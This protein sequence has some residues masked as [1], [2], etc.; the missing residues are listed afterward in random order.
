MTKKNVVVKKAFAVQN[1]RIF[2]GNKS[3]RFRELKLIK[4]IDNKRG[5]FNKIVK[6]EKL[7]FHQVHFLAQDGFGTAAVLSTDFFCLWKGANQ[8]LDG[9]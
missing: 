7:S 5:S 4:R 1:L 3:D 2:E 8:N 6:S 9:L